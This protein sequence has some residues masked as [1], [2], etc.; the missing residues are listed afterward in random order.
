VRLLNGGR[1]IPRGTGAGS[2]RNSGSTAT[3]I[4]AAGKAAID[5]DTELTRLIHDGGGFGAAEVA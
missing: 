3:A 2:I 4:S 5:A 1:F